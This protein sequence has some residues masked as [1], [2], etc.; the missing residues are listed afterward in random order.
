MSTRRAAAA[1]AV[2]HSSLAS[3]AHPQAAQAQEGEEGYDPRGVSQAW[4]HSFLGKK[5]WHPLTFRNMQVVYE[6]EQVGAGTTPG[7]MWV[8]GRGGCCGC[9]RARGVK[10]WHGTV[11]RPRTAQ[12]VSAATPSHPAGFASPAPQEHYEA[13]KKKAESRTEFEAEQAYLKTLSLLRCSGA[14]GRGCES[15]TAR[16]G[17]AAGRARV[18]SPAGARGR[19][20]VP[21][22]LPRPTAMPRA[23]APRSRRS[24]GSGR[25]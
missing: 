8:L 16:A 4:T 6:K 22:S 15:A 3:T 23:T 17:R 9:W 13:E 5:P 2:T 24:I 12:S 10:G 1:T 21:A 20:P 7:M 14:G 18:P 19:V 11:H 25:A